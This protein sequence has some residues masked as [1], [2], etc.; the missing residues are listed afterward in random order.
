MRIRNVFTA[1]M[2]SLLLQG[3]PARAVEALK[4]GGTAAD[5]AAATALTQISTALG[6][7]VSYAGIREALN[8]VANH[9]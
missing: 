3:S 7:N 5:A 4:R 9:G 1:M 2:T 6:A 8:L